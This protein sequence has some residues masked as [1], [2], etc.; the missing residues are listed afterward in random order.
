MGRKISLLLAALLLLGGCYAAQPL[1][2]PSPSAA[3]TSTPTA[4]PTPTPTPT[5]EPTQEVKELWGFPIDDTHD[6][7]EVPTGGE[8]GTVLVTV[9]RGEELG[10]E[11]YCY[12]LSVWDKSDLT[13]PIQT[14][15]EAQ[16][17]LG[18]GELM[19]ANFDGYTDFLYMWN[20]M[21]INWPFSLYVWDEE[22]GRFIFETTFVGRGVSIDKETQTI[23]SS[24]HYTN[25]SGADEIYHWE[26]GELICFRREEYEL[27]DNDLQL[28][29]YVTY[30]WIDGEWQEISREEY[31]MRGL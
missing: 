1:E 13:T 19:D 31:A 30:E 23:V 27:I 5:S 11:G 18:G 6:A 12:K 26:N 24:V 9:E 17:E 15:E 3:E 8:L 22:Q 20:P 7:F 28:T 21:S 29:E 4:P 16:G 2:D 14:L 25:Y 10:E